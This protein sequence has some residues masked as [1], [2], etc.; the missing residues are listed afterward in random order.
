MK[1]IFVSNGRSG[2]PQKS[3]V[4]TA[5]EPLFGMLPPDLFRLM[6]GDGRWFYAGLLEHLDGELFGVG[7]GPARQREAIDAI[8]EYIDRHGR[9]APVQD[10]GAV[11]E[12]SSGAPASP[13]SVA[14]ERLLSTGW[15]VE[16]RDR[17]RRSVDLDR[18]ARLLLELMLDM[19]RGCTRSYGGEVLQ[20]LSS[21]EGAHADPA[22]RSEGVRNAARASRSFLSH[23]RSVS[24]ALRTAERHVSGQNGVASMFGAFFDDFVARHLVEDYKRLHTQ[25]N[26]F[27]FRARIVAVA[28]AMLSDPAMLGSLSLAYQR[29]GR[30]CGPE[31]ARDAV[32]AELNE[33]LRAFSS[34]D[35]H[36]EMIEDISR[37][38]ERRLRNMVRHLERVSAADTGPVAEAMLAL[39]QVGAGKVSPGPLGLLLPCVPLGPAHLFQK[40]RR[41]EPPA[42]RAIHVPTPDPAFLAFQTAL[43][44]YQERMD[45]NPESIR[46]YLEKALPVGSR[47][48]AAELPLTKLDDFVAFHRL[49]MLGWLDDPSLSRDFALEL[50]DGRFSSD[51]IACSDFAIRRKG[52]EGMDA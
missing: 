43:L 51:W 3:R 49:T 20:V 38:M 27:R 45:A 37:G 30:A 29:E 19:K 31:E 25:S 32:S 2:R 16:H 35:E 15:I 8:A 14:Y 17:Y 48:T 26:P 46:S 47:K 40:A 13:A 4:L 39:G 36:L 12:V 22:E 21:L 24:G 9:G 7:A 33:V 6:T 52:T 11:Q 34:L 5:S 23:L 42:R 50:L 10:D 44:A 28:E 1:K 41:R 18:G